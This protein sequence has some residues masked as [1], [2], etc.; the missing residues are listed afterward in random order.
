MWLEPV[1]EKEGVGVA[2][3][4]GSGLG[5]TGPCGPFCVSLCMRVC[6][7]SSDGNEL[8]VNYVLDIY[9]VHSKCSI[10]RSQ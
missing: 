4:S 9:V 2:Q 10:S 8:I 5:Q 6:M 3:R 7:N 1:R